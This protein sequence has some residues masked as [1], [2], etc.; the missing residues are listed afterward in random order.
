MFGD[1]KAFWEK[2]PVASFEREISQILGGAAPDLDSSLTNS[3]STHTSPFPTLTLDVLLHPDLLIS[4]AGEVQ[5][6][7]AAWRRRRAGVEGA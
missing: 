6:W 2:S 3:T 1:A 4:A 5:F 7:E